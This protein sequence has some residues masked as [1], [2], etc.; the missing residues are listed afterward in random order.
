M[1]LILLR[2]ENCMQFDVSLDMVL[3]LLS[4][5]NETFVCGV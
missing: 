5:V 3:M 1:S 4:G 2:L